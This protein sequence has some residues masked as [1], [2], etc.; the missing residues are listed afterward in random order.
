M[1][2]P[3]NIEGMCTY[4]VY[5]R[6]HLPVIQTKSSGSFAVIDEAIPSQWN[7]HQPWQGI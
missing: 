5:L 4:Y 3:E 2:T 1:A 7:H 6:L